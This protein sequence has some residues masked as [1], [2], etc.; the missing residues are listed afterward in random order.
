[1]LKFME[2]WTGHALSHPITQ[3]NNYF[4]SKA[5][6][7]IIPFKFYIL[8]FDDHWQELITSFRYKLAAILL[9]WKANKA[10]ATEEL[11]IDDSDG[12]PNDL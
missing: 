5:C 8:I 1:M 3:V 11:Q 7:I 4:V 6:T 2:Y 12:D 10:S 9:C